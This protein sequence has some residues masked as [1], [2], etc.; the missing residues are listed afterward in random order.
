MKTLKNNSIPE[1]MSKDSILDNINHKEEYKYNIIKNRK[2]FKANLKVKRIDDPFDTKKIFLNKTNFFHFDNVD[3]IIAEQV[4]EAAIKVLNT[5]FIKSRGYFFYSIYNANDI[6]N[7]VNSKYFSMNYTFP[8]LQTMT[9]DFLFKYKLEIYKDYPINFLTGQYFSALILRELGMNIKIPQNDI[10]VF[11]L[12][13]Q[14]KSNIENF[15]KEFENDLRGYKEGF[16]SKNIWIKGSEKVKFNGNSIP[17]NFTVIVPEILKNYDYKKFKP[18]YYLS[19]YNLL[20]NFD[21]NLLKIGL[22]Y[23]LNNNLTLIIH[24]DFIN[25]IKTLQFDYEIKNLKL[26]QEFRIAK[27]LEELKT[28]SFYKNNTNIDLS[29]LSKNLPFYFDIKKFLKS[30]YAQEQATEI[31]LKDKSEIIKDKNNLKYELQKINFLKPFNSKYFEIAN[32]LNFVDFKLFNSKILYPK[33]NKK[34]IFD[35]LENIKDKD[36]EN[37]VFFNIIDFIKSKTNEN[38]SFENLNYLQLKKLIL[39]LEYISEKKVKKLLEYFINHKNEINNNYNI[40]TKYNSYTEFL[41][42]YVLMQIVLNPKLLNLNINEIVFHLMNYLEHIEY[43]DFYQV[44]INENNFIKLFKKYFEK[45]KIKISNTFSEYEYNLIKQSILIK[46]ISEIEKNIKNNDFEIDFEFIINFVY[47]NILKEI[48]EKN[49]SL[50]S[51]EKIEF[52]YQDI[53]VKELTTPLE[54]QATGEK[55]SH[56]VGS[57]TQ[58][59]KDLQSDIFQIESKKEPEFK[60]T[61]EIDPHTLK[62]VQIK[63]F[64]NKNV[65]EEHKEIIQEIIKNI[66]EKL[67]ERNISF[68]DIKDIKNKGAIY[69]PNRHAS[70]FDEFF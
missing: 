29:Q 40:L 53:I 67:K 42:S 30:F 33:L 34:N 41:I 18:R 63:G 62:I 39:G 49:K 31:L 1:Y 24:P 58:R 57:Y 21:I 55:M 44:F 7:I 43:R 11:I 69:E 65:N 52:E 37:I 27:K 6:D 22:M 20:D 36:I 15:E 61:C 32:K 47:E 45:L 13:I 54:L 51:F 3:K 66:Q 64:A 12:D 9:L 35:Y 17:I 16:E 28:L 38:I 19:F 10:D 46:M 23:D 25:F 70:N 60:Y 59:V 4:T 48:E 56:C 8:I 26:Y 2:F 14:N 5:Y 50:I 68:K